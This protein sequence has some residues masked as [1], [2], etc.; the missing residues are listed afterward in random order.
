MKKIIKLLFVIIAV[1]SISLITSC[2]K[3]CTVKFISDENL[4][5]SIQVEKGQCVENVEISKENYL[6]DGWMYNGET[7]NFETKIDKD[8]ELVAKWKKLYNIT[9]DLSGGKMN[10]EL[11]MTFA[12]EE[13]VELPIPTKSGY[14]FIGWFEGDN[15][16]AQVENKDYN[17]VAK[18]HAVKAEFEINGALSMTHNGTTKLSIKYTNNGEKP[19]NIV[20]KIINEEIVSV[21]DKTTTSL[22][23]YGEKPGQTQVKVTATFADGTSVEKYVTVS[24]KG[25]VYKIKYE[26]NAN[27]EMI[28]PSDAPKEY[29]TENQYVSFPLLE[30]DHYVFAGW[31]IEGYEGVY[32]GLTPDD[33][34]EGNLVLSPK[35]LYPHLE[36]SYESDNVTVKVGETNKVIVDAFDLTEGQLRKGFVFSSLNKNVATISEDGVITGVSEGYAEIVVRVYYDQT[37]SCSIGI[38]V[39]PEGA[40]LN[41]VLEYFVGVAK[42][43]NIVKNIEVTGW[44]RVYSYELKTSVIGYLFE[45]LVITENI[46]PLNNGVRP[47]T[48]Y[49]KEYICVHDTGDVEYSAKDWSETVYNNFNSSTGKQYGASYQYVIDN[50][51]CYHNIPDNERSY[52]AGDGNRTYEEI[53]SGVYGTNKYPEITITEDGYYAIDGVKSTI[54]APTYNGQILKTSDINDNGIRCVIVNGQYY[55]GKTWYSETYRKISNYG[56]N[57]NSI[58]IE[59]CITQGEDVYYTWQRLAKLV[60]KLMDENDLTIDDVVTHHFF[61][62]KNCPQT[63]REAGFYAHFKDL[64]LIEYQVLQFIKSGYTISLESF[65]PDYVNNSGRVLK[66][67]PISKVVSYRIIVEKNGVQDSVVLTTTIQNTPLN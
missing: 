29:N 51:D 58:G 26:L 40:S 20:W 14:E 53:P 4:Y 13:N 38:T 9:F 60:A 3:K 16:I 49:K 24:V 42:S 12:E 54:L 46:A 41:E 39:L 48:V 35:W 50:K 56:G 5:T 10:H 15:Q 62:G 52:H 63:M 27:D 34:V 8:I 36:L 66:T 33:D 47:G 11:N 37:I 2:S 17:L 43:N 55:L 21:D 31:I 1:F 7:F 44:Q 28:F 18:W 61:S 32:K 57:N 19:K 64:V 30:R 59:S 45:D 25:Q 23:L 65:N 67:T 22:T 6:F